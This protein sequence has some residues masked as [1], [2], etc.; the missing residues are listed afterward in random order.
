MLQF[1]RRLILD[2]I[3]ENGRNMGSPAVEFGE[4]KI[5]VVGEN[6]Y[7]GN[8]WTQ[9]LFGV[10]AF[11]LSLPPNTY[12]VVIFPDGSSHNMEG[13]LREVPRGLY[14]LQYIDKHD[15][16]ISTAPVSEMARDGEKL[17]LKVIVRYRIINPVAAWQI[18]NPIETLIEHLQTDL[19]QY[20]RAHD[21]NDIADSPDPRGES[22]LLS[23]FFQR[24]Q[25]R[26]PLS[27]AILIMGVDLKEFGGDK[28]WVEIRR[29][30]TIQ[31]KQAQ[32]EKENLEHQK[33]MDQLKA[34]AEK[35][36]AEYKTNVDA[37]IAKASAE[38]EELKSKILYE[39]QKRDAQIE[40]LRKKDQRRQELLIEMMKGLSQSNPA[41]IKSAVEKAMSWQ[42]TQNDVAPVGDERASESEKPKDLADIILNLLK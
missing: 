27:R 22:K 37:I 30:D 4:K 5:S 35:L 38:K 42:D 39:S 20:I 13:G 24:H 41:E 16:L 2:G 1:L 31:K 9:W 34:A 15:R 10:S 19:A 26:N 25:N 18:E 7:A 14:K 11:Y 6:L 23:F 21:H 29:S 8:T 32:F 12:G 3:E 33:E 36:R 17:A 28:E 40:N